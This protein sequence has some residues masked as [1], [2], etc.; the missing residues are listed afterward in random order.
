M[1]TVPEKLSSLIQVLFPWDQ[2]HGVLGRGGKVEGEGD[3]EKGKEKRREDGARETST[4]C[5]SIV[6]A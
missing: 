5:L 1:N 4:T 6:H 3:E 2:R